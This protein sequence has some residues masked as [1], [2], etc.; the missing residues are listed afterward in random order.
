MSYTA[1]CPANTK[2]NRF[3]GLVYGFKFLSALN[4]LYPI[5]AI[6]FAENGVSYTEISV[7]FIIWSLSVAAFALPLGAIADKYSRKY[8]VFAGQFGKVFCFVIWFACPNF[9]G[10]LVGFMLWGIEWIT[11]TGLFEA[12]VY[13]ELKRLKNEN[14]YTKICGRMSGISTI[15]YIFASLGS[16]MMPL[17]YENI[18][19]I[20]MSMVLLSAVLMMFM[21]DTQPYC[22]VKEEKITVVIRKGMQILAH[23]TYI[24]AI[25]ILYATIT[26]LGYIDEYFGLVGLEIGM[27]KS[28]VGV[29]FVVTCLCHAFGSWTAWR[30]KNISYRNILALSVLLGILFFAVFCF[31]N[32]TVISLLSISFCLCGILTTLLLSHYQK[33]IPCKDRAL[34]MSFYFLVEQ[35]TTILSYLIM[36]FGYM[37]GS[38][39]A[40]FL[41]LGLLVIL[42]AL[43]FYIMAERCRHRRCRCRC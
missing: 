39:A 22:E 15:G 5:Y 38:Y 8:I 43:F 1:S 32:L 2:L 4:F 30:F 42:C 11:S 35:I 41:G 17:G 37:T 28:A 26:G 10:Y 33:M 6:M 24:L 29:L 23:R 19:Y 36:M 34:M 21:P 40:G 9:W 13:D 18:M 27:D 14:L 25:L 20:S 7:L 12:Y 16:F 3:L 31:Y